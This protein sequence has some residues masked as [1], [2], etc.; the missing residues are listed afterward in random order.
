M[1]WGTSMLSSIV[2]LVVLSVCH[3]QEGWTI[4]AAVGQDVSLQCGVQVQGTFERLVWKLDTNS[5]ELVAYSFG[6]SVSCNTRKKENC[7]LRSDG[8]LELHNLQETDSGDYFCVVG[9]DEKYYSQHTLV[10][11]PEAA[12][13]TCPNSED[14]F[15]T[16]TGPDEIVP[17]YTNPVCKNTDVIGIVTCDPASGA[18]I[19]IGVTEIVCNCTHSDNVVDTCKIPIPDVSPFENC[20][21]SGSVS[22]SKEHTQPEFATSLSLQPNVTIIQGKQLELKN[23]VTG[24]PIP[25]ILCYKDGKQLDPEA[26]YKT[27]FSERLAML[28]AESTKEGDQGMFSCVAVNPEGDDITSCNVLFEKHTKPEFKTHLQPHMTVIDGK[29]LKLECSVNGY[30]NPTILWYKDGK[31]LDSQAGYKTTFSEGFAILTCESTKEGDEGMFSCKA[32][33]PAGDNITSCKVVVERSKV[34]VQPSDDSGTLEGH[35]DVTDSGKPFTNPNESGYTAV[36]TPG[37]LQ[38]VLFDE[39]P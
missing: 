16:Q 5:T 25:T 15:V 29:P 2:Q 33:N 34:M 24:Y 31:L 28:T 38:Y 23:S 37:M 22:G 19:G 4:D 7:D 20:S 35:S 21:G 6:G 36:D 11:H 1:N 18:K 32:V 10:V 39:T 17:A 26:G 8:S 27:T 9:L 30:P 13:E 3:A 12:F 14:V